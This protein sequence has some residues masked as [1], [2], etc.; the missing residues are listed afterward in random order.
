[1]QRRARYESQWGLSAKD[2]AALTEVPETATWFD[3][4]ASAAADV[5]G[6]DEGAAARESAKWILNAAAKFARERGVEPHESGITPVQLAGVIA[7]RECGDVGSSAAMKLFEAL[8]DCDDQPRALAES[9]NLLQVSDAGTLDAWIDEALDAQ[10][11]AAEDFAAG[12]DAAAGRII[13]CVMKAS[14]GA[15]DAGKV[16]ARLVERLR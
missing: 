6:L 13:G 14:G 7:L 8:C 9:R 16:R 10:P 11:Q 15:A 12:K 3:A 5:T 2:A 1:M 4:C